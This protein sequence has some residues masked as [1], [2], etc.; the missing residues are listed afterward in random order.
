MF[1]LFDPAHPLYMQYEPKP[2]KIEHISWKPYQNIEAILRKRPVARG[3]CEELAMKS[4]LLGAM[5]KPSEITA[6]YELVAPMKLKTVVEIGTASGGVFW[7]LCQLAASDAKVVSIDLP[8][9]PFGGGYTAE[10]ERK[11]H[12][13]GKKGQQLFFLK[14][15]SHRKETLSKLRE[16]IGRAKIDLLV[17]DGDHTYDGVKAD[18]EMYSPLVKGGGVVMFHD[19]CHHPTIPECQVERFWKEIKQTGRK[20]V[21][22]IDEADRN[23]GG[24]GVVFA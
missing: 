18:W 16:I 6:F 10:E 15:D 2:W 3:H 5:Q 24:I 17:I 19:I 7:G 12:L 23:W 8:G 21:E 14:M 11:F 4:M 9:G 13:F 20:T 1:Q 22:Y